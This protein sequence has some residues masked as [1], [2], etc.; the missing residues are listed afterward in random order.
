MPFRAVTNPNISSPRPPSS[1]PF[2]NS[3]H[4]LSHP[5]SAASIPYPPHLSSPSL[6][7][8]S[9]PLLAFSENT[10]AGTWCLTTP[11]ASGYVILH[12]LCIVKQQCQHLPQTCITLYAYRSLRPS[13]YDARIGPGAPCLHPPPSL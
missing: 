10:C 7:P 11:P 1:V 13:I 6:L 8:P 3:R 9:S 2:S 4:A 5:T 12:P